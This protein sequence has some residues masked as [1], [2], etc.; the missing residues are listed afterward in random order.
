MV[1]KRLSKKANVAAA[2]QYVIPVRHPEV[3]IFSFLFVDAG[4]LLGS[5][6]DC[7]L[8]ELFSASDGA[9]NMASSDAETWRAPSREASF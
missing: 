4:T 7:D 6:G 8:E 2:S 5:V 1:V 9:S 3:R